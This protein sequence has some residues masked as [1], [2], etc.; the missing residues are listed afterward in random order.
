MLRNC[1]KCL[2]KLLPKKKQTP[3]IIIINSACA[4]SD[5]FPRNRSPMMSVFVIINVH[6]F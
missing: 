5:F 6:Y 4:I 1:H 2:Y 3:S